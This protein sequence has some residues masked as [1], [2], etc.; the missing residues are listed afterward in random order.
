MAM[1]RAMNS[2]TIWKLEDGVA[3]RTL[4]APSYSG[5]IDFNVPHP[6]NLHQGLVEELLLRDAESH[7]ADFRV[8]WQWKFVDMDSQGAGKPC[9]VTLQH[10]GTN[11]TKVVLARYVLGA[12][13]AR[14]AVRGW[15]AK[16]GVSMETQP[17]TDRYCIQDLTGITS[18]FPDLERFSYVMITLITLSDAKIYHDTG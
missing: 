18:D 9:K 7:N 2:Q 13:G 14:S 12:D 5:A 3:K 8:H 16:F 6:R 11:E 10:L 17:T 4:I 1:S 15:A